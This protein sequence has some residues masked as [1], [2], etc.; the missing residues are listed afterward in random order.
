MIERLSFPNARG[1]ALAAELHHPAEG[2]ARGIAVVL[3]H[4]MESSRSGLKHVRLANELAAR[5]FPALRFDFA[6]CGDSEGSFEDMTYTREVEDLRGAVALVRNRGVDRFALFGSSMG[7]A[8]A[9]LFAG[10]EPAPAGLVGVATLAAVARPG[11]V[12]S[13]MVSLETYDRWKRDEFLAVSEG[14][15][16]R[17][18][19]ME[20]AQRIDVPAAAARVRVPVLVIHGA[21]DEVVPVEDGRV[22]HAA[23]PHDRKEL[24]I[25]DGAD[26]RF[27]EPAHLDRAMAKLASWLPASFGP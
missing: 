27:S 22:I 23:V 20:D 14:R 6:G 12:P 15:R 1:Q 5:G 25:V 26:H 16:V 8:V 24:V 13:P 19:L 4:G 7:G 2:V 11:R 9:L 10:G 3:C 17:F 21:A 18:T